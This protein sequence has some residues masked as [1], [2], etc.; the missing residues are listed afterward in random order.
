MI[1][2][3]RARAERG[4]AMVEMAISMLLIIPIF[5]YALFLDDLLRYRLNQQEAVVSTLWDFTVQSYDHPLPTYSPGLD[6]G[7][8]TQVQRNSRLMFCDHE[9]GL[10][11][12]N[13]SDKQTGEMT[14]C[15]STEHHKGTA[16][17][18]HECWLNG[19][20]HQITCEQPDG[21]V[22]AL[23]D[24]LWRKVQSGE[25]ANGGMFSCSGNL[26]VENYLLPRSFL[27][28]FAGKENTLSKEKWDD[29][30]N[31]HDNAKK[32]TAQTA[33]YF[34]KDQFALVADSW[35]Y[36]ATQQIRPGEKGASGD[37]K[38]FWN[39]TQTAFTQNAAYLPYKGLAEAFATQLVSQGL[40]D[41]MY[42]PTFT[43]GDNP[44]TPN[45]SIGPAKAPS[46]KV[47]QDS[48]DRSYFSSPWKDWSQD[49]YQGTYN[50]RGDHY[51]GCQDEQSC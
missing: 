19:N 40:L 13:S 31:A 51:M 49:A 46:A 1:R 32:G 2:S 22:G 15:S 23:S 33:Y 44:T 18:A 38:L 6:P 12:Y 9:S 42:G 25:H 7:G 47:K 4:A 39:D 10:E 48:G 41:P 30:G 3:R 29:D 34:D 5:L 20:A 50:A 37:D 16:V 26:I 28:E 21:A 14:D 24:S 36:A 45:V 17:V 11:H 35:A 43:A 27:Q 8:A